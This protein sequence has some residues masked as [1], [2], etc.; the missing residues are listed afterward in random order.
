MQGAE[1]LTKF[2]ADTSQ[3]DKATK[4][5]DTSISNL[6]KSFTLGTLAA[7]GISKALG[8]MNENLDSAIKRTDTLNN[9]PKVMSNLG[10]GADEAQESINE[11]SDKLQGLPTPLDSAASAVQRFTSGNSDIK[12]STKYFLALNNALLAGGASSDIQS[13]ALE[14]LSQAYAKGKPDMME[15]RTMLMAMPAQMKQIATAMGFVDATALGEALRDG[16]VSMDE[17]METITRLNTEG[18][19]DFASF[20]EQARNSTGGIQT[21][22]TNMKTAFTRGV[23]NI[24]SSLNESLEP[25]GGLSGVISKIGQVGE[26]AFSMVGKAIQQIMP[27]VIK[28]VDWIIKNHE[29]LEAIIIPIVA[30]IAAFSAVA[31]VISIVQALSTAVGVL[32]AM[33]MA[34]PIGLIVAAIVAVIAALVL[35]YKKCTWF[36]NAVNKV[37]DFIKKIIE[38]LKPVIQKVFEFVKEWFDRTVA[39]WTPIFKALEV[40]IKKYIEIVTT[41]MSK[42]FNAVK[43]YVTV[44]YNV[45]KA[46]ATWVW[47]N[48]LQPII[49]YVKWCWDTVYKVV[50]FGIEL[51]KAIFTTLKEHVWDNTLKPIYEFTKDIFDKIVNKIKEKVEIIKAVFTK[52]KETV[53]GVF[54]GIKSTIKN[55]FSTVIQNI[56]DQVNRL[57][58]SVN[59]VIDKINSVEIAGKSPNI[60]NIPTLNTGTNYVPQDTL[61]MIH[62]GEAVVPKKFN[63]YANGINNSTLAG[64]GGR[65]TIVVNVENNMEMDSL[66][67]MVNRIKTYSGGAKNDYNF[68]MGR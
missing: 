43:T 51:A 53:E 38:A 35:L 64:M 47:N 22:I 40:I 46:I 21:S 36:R 62:K 41:V 59:W 8:V 60:S 12:R 65:T 48:V 6:T 26:K 7:K 23:A 57:I 20:E 5:F 14:Q 9:F 11:L 18:V 2:T 37:V 67:Q 56:K 3:V 28:I 44:C 34:N 31:K 10:I 15:W 52:I 49:N 30:F 55:V 16:S 42:I 50:S 17:F 54:N 45:F 1:I 33:M 58:G 29:V 25:F 4:S 24:I 39:F 61:A 32:N 66:G 68:G 13:S 27:Y 19:G 63:P